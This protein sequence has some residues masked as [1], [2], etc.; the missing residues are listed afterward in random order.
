MLGNGEA[1][2]TLRWDK[3][4]CHRFETNQAR[5]LM[6]V[7]AYNLLHMLRSFYIIGEGVKRSIEWL[8][9]RLIKVGAK[10]IYH[11]RRWHVHV[12][13]TFPLVRH[14]QTVFG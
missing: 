11:G 1:Q 4:S 9:K 2:N 5:L 13:S 6:G 12:A 7:I 8:I 3:T 10:V 14:Y